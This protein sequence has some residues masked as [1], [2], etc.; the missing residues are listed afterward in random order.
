MIDEGSIL[1]I[2]LIRVG[3]VL[4]VA[5]SFFKAI[6]NPDESS[7]YFKRIRN[8]ITF[9]VLAESIFQLKNIAI[10]YFKYGGKGGPM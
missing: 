5:Y 3:V 4:R 7:G 9:Y 10:Y 6:G 2:K 8:V 1:L